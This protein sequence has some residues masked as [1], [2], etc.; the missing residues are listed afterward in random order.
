MSVPE[1]EILGFL[2]SQ[3]HRGVLGLM[4]M[5]ALVIIC[6][7]FISTNLTRPL[8]K[9]SEG[10][11]ELARGDLNLEI[12]GINSSD[13]IGEL[14][15]G[16]NSMV[17][18]LRRHVHALTREVAV[19]E[20]YESEMEFAHQ[21]QASL[22]PSDYPAFPE[23]DQFELYG[24][25]RPARHVAGDFFDFFKLDDDQLILVIGDVSGKGMA[26]ALFMAVTRTIVRNQAR[27]GKSPAEILCEAN[28][29]LIEAGMHSLFVTMFIARYAVNSGEITYANAGHPP[30]YKICRDN[31]VSKFGETT[32]TIVGM[33]E[34]A[35]FCDV[36]AKL[37]VD[38][39]LVL[40]TDG[41]PDARSPDGEF[42]GEDNFIDL[43]GI[44]AGKSVKELCEY[45]VDVLQGY[46][47]NSLKD[48]TTLLV[49]KRV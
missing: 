12:K 3:I 17:A 1:A 29:L 30:P 4:L 37:Q 47:G 26:S 23:F 42:F 15:R 21:V 39:W 32:G 18:Q 10:V 46:Q 45:T 36:G 22:L 25:Y 33:L 48:D 49:I 6:I 2:M 14:A 24:I 7:L 9:L 11:R 35:Q 13:E 19:R 44:C 34:E 20:S 16:F 40:Y 5:V 43:L 31:S 41:V 38:E 28:R 8:T 27:S